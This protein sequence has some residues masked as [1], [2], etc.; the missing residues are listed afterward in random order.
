MSKLQGI[1]LGGLLILTLG[2]GGWSSWQE[3][4]QPLGGEPV[5]VKIRSGLGSAD[6]GDLLVTQK[7]IRSQPVWRIY[8]LTQGWTNSLKAGTYD[9]DPQQSLP[10][11]AQQLYEGRIAQVRL[12]VPE[13]WNLKQMARYFEMQGVFP[14]AQFWP[15]VK[16]PERLQVP[17][18]P[19]TVPQLEG[20]LFPDTYLIPVDAL[21][22]QQVV[23]R[24][25]QRFEEVGLPI[26][27]S[28]KTTLSMV[29]WVTLASIVEKEA[30]VAQERSLISGV[31]WQRLQK[32]IPLGS[33]PTVEYAFGITQTPER[34]L[35]YAQVRQKSPYNTYVTPGLPPT[36][37]AAPGKASLESAAQPELTDYLFFVARYDGT[38]IFSQTVAEH[39]QAK[40]KIRQDFKLT[41]QR[42]K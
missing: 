8:L 3:G 41:D 35:T 12:T 19:K 5:R 32:N 34:N 29:E 23:Q 24:M 42:K 14:E 21:S 13:G 2:L 22:A 33:D 1:L 27:Q 28:N 38:H 15:L 6:I 26:Y 7:V 11:I 39:E 20:F 31:F 40:R 30:V 9:F 25:L 36:P 17:W 37:I 10:Q 4:L 16:G 18:L